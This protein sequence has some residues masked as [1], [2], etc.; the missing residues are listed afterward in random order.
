MAGTVKRRT[1]TAPDGSTKTAWRARYRDEFGREH[2][3]QRTTR[4]AAQAWLDE[5][6]SHIVT[7]TWA[8]PRKG[9]QAFGAFAT[10]WAE[11]QNWE[12]STRTSFAQTMRTV[13][14][15]DMPLGKIRRS[16][17]ERW[18]RDEAEKYAAT[19]VHTRLVHVR[20]VFRAAVAERLIGQDPAEGVKPPRK[21]KASA[22]MRMPTTAQ[23]AALLEA[24]EGP[25]H[26][27]IALCAFAGLRLG[28]VVAVQV[29][30][31][32]LQA[33][34]LH[35]A[36]QRQRE[37]LRLPKYGSE[38]VVY[39]P[40]ELVALLAAYLPTVKHPDGWLFVGERGPAQDNWAHA[41]FRKAR[42]AAGCDEVTVHGLRHF[43]ASGL[44]AA[45]C[46]VVTVQ[47]ALG[48]A[49]PS[50]TLN[51]YAHLWPTAEDRTRA[52]AASIMA[53][54]AGTGRARD[55]RNADD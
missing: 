22:A 20:Q 48:H 18:L 24:S 37:E 35:V 29:G 43:Y 25:T 52:G 28:E 16:H 31:V 23:V 45:G 5:Q 14:F 47:R 12:T 10:A 41:R 15:D 42:K 26:L 55:P 50:T 30:D 49:S 7:G 8:D 33:R 44:I 6:T 34:T 9:R 27:L 38:R 3:A 46:D 36:R 17:V 32:D 40:D 54:V 13:P 51:T 1:W 19:T 21:R 4:A 53:A 11:R 39:L 2:S